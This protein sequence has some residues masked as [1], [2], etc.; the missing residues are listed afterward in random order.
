[1]NLELLFDRSVRADFTP[2]LLWLKIIQSVCICRYDLNFNKVFKVKGS[3][4]VFVSALLDVELACRE[5]DS[6]VTQVSRLPAKYIL[7]FDFLQQ[8]AFN[9]AFVHSKC[10]CFE[11]KQVL[12]LYIHS[13][14]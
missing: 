2:F 6:E 8:V 12:T 4:F 13:S 10:Q 14:L 7:F 1:M 11:L 5:H 9:A 3:H